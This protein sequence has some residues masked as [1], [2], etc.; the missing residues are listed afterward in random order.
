M[1]RRP[2]YLRAL[3]TALSENPIAALLGEAPGPVSP[4][5]MQGRSLLH[6]LLTLGTWPESSRTPSQGRLREVE[7]AMH[8]GPR[9]ASFGERTAA[10]GWDLLL[11]RGGR[12]YGVEFEDPRMRRA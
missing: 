8:S 12:R 10:R 9:E 4:D 1:I 2:H 3:E 11:I 5:Y 7:G 6:G